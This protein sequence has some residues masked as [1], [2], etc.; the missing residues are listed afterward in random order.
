MNTTIDISSKNDKYKLSNFEPYAFELDRVPI[1]SMEGF[2]Q[3]LK[4]KNFNEQKEI[5]QLVGKDAKKR[6]RNQDWQ[7]S[8]K[9]WWR[10]TPYPR[11]DIAYTNLLLRAYRHLLDQNEDFRNELTATGNAIFLH[12]IGTNDRTKTVIT[13]IMFCYI[14]DILRKEI[15]NIPVV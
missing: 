13:S 15:K 11:N 2:L 14:L 9:L 7:S 4:F 1:T 8:Q 6:G 10:W 12:S 3:A 5:C